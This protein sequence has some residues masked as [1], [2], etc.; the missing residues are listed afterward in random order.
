M[1]H[2]NEKWGVQAGTG[3]DEFLMET[4]ETCGFVTKVFFLHHARQVPIRILQNL[5]STGAF[6]AVLS[7]F[8]KNTC[9]RWRVSRIFN[10]NS[11]RM[12]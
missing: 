3:L 10:R 4:M 7:K 6:L 2:H 5:Y 1:L 9:S 8:Y 11:L 12:V